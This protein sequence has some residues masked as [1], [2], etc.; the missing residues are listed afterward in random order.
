MVVLT[1]KMGKR[2]PGEVFG[3]RT[4]A[5]YLPGTTLILKRLSMLLLTSCF[6]FPV[7]EKEAKIAK[8]KELGIYKEKRVREE[9]HLTHTQL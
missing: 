1:L 8:E 9:T 4:A 5:V 3:G 7:P 2:F 6:L